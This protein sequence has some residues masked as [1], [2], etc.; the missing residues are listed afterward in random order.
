M[1]LIRRIR[2]R[3]RAGAVAVAATV[4]AVGIAS[5]ATGATGDVIR[6]GKRTAGSGSTAIVSD[7]TGYSTRQSNNHNGDGGAASYGCRA[8]SGKEP[9][10]Y[11]LNHSTSGKVF[12]FQSDGGSPAGEILVKPPTGKTPADVAPFST[13]ATG[14]A[15]GLN[16]DKVDGQSAADIAAAAKPL[17]A[18][19]AA[20]GTSSGN[21]GLAQSN[22]VTHTGTGAYTVTF[23]GDVSKCAY[24]ATETTTTNAGAAAVAPVASNVNALS[25]V[26]RAGGGADGNGPTDP[27]DRPFHLVVNC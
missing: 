11:V 17:F 18:A 6:I 12:R 9:C 22:A 25:V 7:S 13:N 8:N 21:R 16:A 1:N 20:D 2:P 26:T 27:A 5:V 24:S 15:T 10:L 23:A 3:G 14:V 4:F 19:V